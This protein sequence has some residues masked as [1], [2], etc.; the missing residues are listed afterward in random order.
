MNFVRRGISWLFLERPVSDKSTTDLIND[1]T[2]SGA[3]VRER[4]TQT[5]RSRAHHDIVTHIIGIERWAQERIK[6]AQTPA[7]SMPHGEY[8]PYRPA[9]DTP[10]EELPNRFAETREATIQLVQQLDSAALE[11]CVPHNQL[12]ELSVRAWVRYLRVHADLESRKL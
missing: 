2:Q 12:G 4:I 8:D 3:M 6:A 1:L 10:W 9:R 7:Q 11:R 5:D